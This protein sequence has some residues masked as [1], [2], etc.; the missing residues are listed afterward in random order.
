MSMGSCI[1]ASVAAQEI[2]SYIEALIAQPR[3]EDK[4]PYE[5]VHLIQAEAE[6]IKKSA[7]SGWY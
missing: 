1:G 5:I 4:S 6:E 3:F 7:N 2:I